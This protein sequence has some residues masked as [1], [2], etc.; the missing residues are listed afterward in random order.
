[1]AV[2]F[3]M[4]GT[5][6][7][8]ERIYLELW[9]EVADVSRYPGFRDAALKLVG[10]PANEGKHIFTE[11]YGE[12]FPY[13]ELWDKVI[14]LFETRYE[15]LPLPV[16]PGALSLL[17]SL[18]EKGVKTALAS[19]TP[20]PLAQNNLKNAGLYDYIDFF[21]TGEMVHHGKPD[22]E[23]FLLAAKTLGEKPEDC[24]VIEDSPDGIKAAHAAGMK[25]IMIPDLIEPT[26]EIRKMTDGIYN[27]L[28]DLTEIL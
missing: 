18:K 2:I 16:K 7:D 3:D 13:D 23:I 9:P 14:S 8:T 12:D 24:V 20:S 15:T 11:L 26:E 19:S 4:D 1:M 6:L 22:P 28:N 17:R 27:T 5:L 10:I 25:V 21:I